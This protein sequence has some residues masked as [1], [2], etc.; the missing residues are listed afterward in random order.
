MKQK[1]V[2]CKWGVYVLLLLFA[3]PIILN[4]A[5]VT[6]EDP[7]AEIK[8]INK[9]YI[10][11]NSN[12]NVTINHIEDLSAKNIKITPYNNRSQAI[13][14]YYT[15]LNVSININI[16]PVAFYNNY[17]RSAII[18]YSYT[19]I[20]DITKDFR[21]VKLY[22]RSW[23]PRSMGFKWIRATTQKTFPSNYTIIADTTHLSAWSVIYEDWGRR[24]SLTIESDYLDKSLRNFPVFVNLSAANFNF[25]AA[26][27]DGDDVRFTDNEDNPLY[28]EFEN[29][30]G[31]GQKAEIWV[32][33][34]NIS[35]TEDTVFYLYYNNSG[36][37]DAQDPPN[38]W[39][40]NYLM[41]QHCNDFDGGGAWMLDSTTNDID[42]TP[43]GTRLKPGWVGDCH[44]FDG[45]DAHI[46][47]PDNA[48]MGPQQG[49]VEAWV[50]MDTLGADIPLIRIITDGATIYH[51]FSIEWIPSQGG[52]TN[53]VFVTVGD[54]AWEYRGYADQAIDD[55]AWH[56][57]AYTVETG[58]GNKL[59]SDSNHH[60]SSMMAY[61]TGDA[62]TTKF[63]NIVDSI[64]KGAFGAVYYDSVWY[65]DYQL[66]LDEIRISNIARNNTWLNLTVASANDSII[67]YGAEE[68][69][70][71]PP[72]PPVQYPNHV[73]FPNYQYEYVQITINDSNY[74]ASD[75]NVTYPSNYYQNFSYN[76]DLEVYIYG[77][78][79]GLYNYTFLM[80]A[81]TGTW[82][83]GSFIVIP[84]YSQ[85]SYSNYKDW[86][87]F[88]VIILLFLVF[89]ILARKQF[90]YGFLTVFLGLYIFVYVDFIPR[91]ISFWFI[92]F[93]CAPLLIA[94]GD[95][96]NRA[97]GRR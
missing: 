57:W 39:N 91:S 46:I 84:N 24:I 64:G 21:K 80:N 38:V 26:M 93:G 16:S 32:N 8:T 4:P 94:A 74:I 87:F 53:T 71:V 86:L 28:Y 36:Q 40:K 17:F 27:S 52:A 13:T 85:L 47:I 1:N 33:I 22:Y 23:D 31:A 55:G 20:W 61:L 89:F 79:T 82:Y 48:F 41:V 11:L 62:S 29:W 95:F 14:Q 34:T 30:T 65:D 69:Q 42:C 96:F 12:F 45:S 43:T 18:K 76:D 3:T 59:Y 9:N 67:T 78:E 7:A 81:T 92:L 51:D 73:S 66:N 50:R 5:I 60:D 77:N 56:H 72:T 90:I 83:N 68:E 19:G 58:Y 35:H 37:V 6:G 88:A 70:T 15:D 63:T 2:C 25:S 97:A 10:A 54:D 75:I 44:H 49:T